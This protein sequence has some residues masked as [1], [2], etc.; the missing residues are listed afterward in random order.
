MPTPPLPV[1]A[2]LTVGGYPLAILVDPFS[3]GIDERGAPWWEVQYLGSGMDKD[4]AKICNALKGIG[5]YVSVPY[6]FPQPHRYIGSPNLACQSVRFKLCGGRRGGP[7]GSQAPLAKYYA[8]YGVPPFDVFGDQNQV[9]FGD[10]ATPWTMYSVRGGE[11]VIRWPASSDP[12][13]LGEGIF[14]FEAGSAGDGIAPDVTALSCRIALKD[15]IIRRS[16]IPNFQEFDD[17]LTSL[18][19]KTN[20]APVF[21]RPAGELLVRPNDYDVGVD[22]SGLKTG[23]FTV[24][25]SWKQWGWNAEPVPGKFGVFSDIET[26]S[27]AKKYQSAS[28]TDL[29]RFGL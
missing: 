7:L 24:V 28:Y 14:V 16:M 17:L 26:P 18:Q 11:E 27:G 20:N 25:I 19:N 6:G 3:G 1:D 23:D 8:T 13:D 9:A 15:Y 21:G 10:E 2:D 4:P 5:E 22:P 12:A 29:L